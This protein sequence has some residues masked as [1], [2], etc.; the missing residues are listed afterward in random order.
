MHRH[1][2]IGTFCTREDYWPRRSKQKHIEPQIAYEVN[3][4]RT[5]GKLVTGLMIGRTLIAADLQPCTTLEKKR[6]TARRASI[7][8]HNENIPCCQLLHNTQP[9][10]LESTSEGRSSPKTGRFHYETL[11]SANLIQ[12]ESDNQIKLIL[13]M[14]MIDCSSK[15]IISIKF[16]ERSNW[17]DGPNP[18]DRLELFVIVP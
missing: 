11:K 1:D 2:V 7:Q 12:N 3:W 17:F 15:S 6:Y 10:N 8:R 13:I 14:K 18:T 5:S 9:A 4:I 16:V